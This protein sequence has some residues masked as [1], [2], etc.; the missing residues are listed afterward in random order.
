M[1]NLAIDLEVTRV[2]LVDEGA[3]TAAFIKLYKRKEQ[4]NHMPIDEI[5]AKMQPEHAQVIRDEIAKA[6]TTPKID[7][8]ED[9]IDG[10][11]DEEKEDLKKSLEATKEELQ[12]ANDLYQSTFD[13]LETMKAAEVAKSKPNF[14]DVIKGL[15]PAAQELMKSLKLAKDTAEEEVRKA[16]AKELHDEAVIKAKDLSNLPVEQDKLVE[17]LKN[18]SAEVVEVL[19]VANKAIKDG[20]IFEEVGKRGDQGAP[21]DAQQAWAQ[22]EKKADEIAKREKITREKAVGI[23]VRENADLY[24]AYLDG[25]AN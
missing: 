25:G 6:A 23:A 18:A 8:P 10:G 14:E 12:K 15:E 24:K 22:I 17:V 7:D 3:N 9:K 1:P 21:S 19:K 2:D 5:L 16:K 11:V 4:D 20:G 13:E